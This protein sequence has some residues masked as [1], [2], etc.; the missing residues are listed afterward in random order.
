MSKPRF[1]IVDDDSVSRVKL[2]TILSE[3]GDCLSAEGGNEAIGLFI[4]EFNGGKPFDMVALDIDMPGIKGTEVLA[5]IRQF[6]QSVEEPADTRPRARVVMITSHSDRAHVQKA[7]KYGCDGYIVKPFNQ[8]SIFDKLAQFGWV[9]GLEVVSSG[10]RSAAQSSPAAGKPEKATTPQSNQP[11]LKTAIVEKIK[12]LKAG[13]FSLPSQPD[14]YLELKKLIED[15]ADLSQVA[16]LLKNHATITGT[17]I[18]ISNT[19]KYRRVNPNKSLAEA[20]ARLGMEET[21]EQVCAICTKGMCTDVSPKYRE[22][23]EE[24]WRTSLACAYTCEILTTELNQE[25][26]VDPFTMG[27]MHDIGKIALLRI[28]EFLEKK[29]LYGEEIGWEE[30]RPIMNQYE[31]VL[32]AMLLQQ[33]RLP[34]DYQKVARYHGSKLPDGG[35]LVALDITNM[36]IDLIP[37]LDVSADLSTEDANERVQAFCDKYRGSF[38]ELNKDLVLSLL[39]RVSGTLR[40]GLGAMS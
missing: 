23:G 26:T 37:L 40:E 32:G 22:F 30:I 19:A 15:G 28:F 21:L 24:V 12:E 10:G 14:V 13:K 33:W 9:A 2:K 3:V 27:L 38:S 7:V 20:I 29:G 5:R 31:G 4:R 25:L 6:E 34:P 11:S 1:L 8:M 35:V 17:L 39:E 36:A 18:K 16:E